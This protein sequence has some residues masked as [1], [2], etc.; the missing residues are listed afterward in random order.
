MSVSTLSR[1]GSLQAREDAAGAA[2]RT[3]ETNVSETYLIAAGGTGGHVIPA[4]EVARELA[5]RGRRTVFVGTASGM[6]TRLVPQSGFVL[7]TVD[8]GPLNRVSLWTK[9]STLARLPWSVVQAAKLIRQ[10][11]PPAVLSLGG[12]ASGP[13]AAAAV[14]LRVPVIAMEPN[15]YPGLANRLAA[16]W[17]RLALLGFDEARGHFPDGRS[18]TVGVPV[19][20]EFFELPRKQHVGPSTVLITGGSQGSKALNDAAVAA[21][22]RWARDGFPGGLRILHQTGTAQYNDVQ[23][24]YAR[25]QS[26]AEIVLEAVPF[27]DDMPTAFARADLVVCRSGASALAELAAAGKASILVPLA[28]STDNHQARNA[29]AMAAAGAARVAPEAEW[30]GDRMAAEIGA[31][32]GAPG[33]LEEME[34]AARGLARPQAAAAVASALEEA[35]NGRSL[36]RK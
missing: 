34:D 11:R 3:F 7:E 5:V 10:Y 16:R 14:L 33:R 6:E 12:Y 9:I 20:K 23:A 13:L 24:A 2:F 27:I 35:G 36:E 25:L 15:A 28:T 1:T 29:E 26:S 19:R 17:V 4:L 8:I 31:V 32:L 22:E 21:A 30:T 18:E